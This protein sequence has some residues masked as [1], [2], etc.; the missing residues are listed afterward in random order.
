MVFVGSFL[1]CSSRRMLRHF[2]L[3]TRPALSGK[4]RSYRRAPYPRWP[5]KK[6]RAAAPRAS[7]CHGFCRAKN[8]A[9][10]RGMRV[11]CAPLTPCA[12]PPALRLA[13]PAPSLGA[14]RDL[15]LFIPPFSRSF[16]FQSVKPYREKFP[17][18]FTK[19]SYALCRSAGAYRG[20]RFFR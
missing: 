15:L 4:V 12:R 10:P 7:G 6:A 8:R 1:A 11:A 17:N 13:P 14:T 19:V 20:L 18:G 5:Y 3:L 2:T 9:S 16:R